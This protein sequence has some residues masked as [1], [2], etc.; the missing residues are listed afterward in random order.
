MPWEYTV[1]PQWHTEFWPENLPRQTS[2]D[3]MEMVQ[4]E[5]VIEEPEPI[6]DD[7]VWCE[8]SSNCGDII[9]EQDIPYQSEVVT[10]M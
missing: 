1:H 3:E 5:V 8:E 2:Q 10:G 9:L 4:D 7:F 6:S